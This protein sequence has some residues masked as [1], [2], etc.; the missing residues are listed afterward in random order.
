MS[1]LLGEG[2][3]AESRSVRETAAYD[4]LD[5]LHIS[6]RRADHDAAMTME[7]CEEIDKL[8]GV[9]M[10]KNLFLCN[11]QKT[12]FYLLLMPGDKPFRTKELSGQL[13]VARLSFGSAEDM[14]AMLGLLPG[15]VSVMGLIND[16]EHRVRL[17]IDKEL[18]DAAEIGCHPLVNTSSVAFSMED[19]LKKVLPATG[20][21][22][23]VVELSRT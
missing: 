5:R 3:P 21:I 11:R 18:M 17:L 4:Y 6:Y 22:P 15:A 13:G 8:L 2:R 7:A 19:L 23:T 12:D 9:R 10:C 20:H 1:I 16:K 14:E